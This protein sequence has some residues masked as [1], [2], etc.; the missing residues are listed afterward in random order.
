MR[1]QRPQ[2]ATGQ[3]LQQSRD[4]QAAA[5]RQGRRKLDSPP[6]WPPARRRRQQARSD[7][8]IFLDVSDEV[9]LE[10]ITSACID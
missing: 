7:S 8:G 4:T 2:A 6:A 3:G 1:D 5:R 9:S 10:P